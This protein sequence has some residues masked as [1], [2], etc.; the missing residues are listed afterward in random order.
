MREVQ[1]LRIVPLYFYFYFLSL[2]KMGERELGIVPLEKKKAEERVE[3]DGSGGA[4]N[5]HVR[6]QKTKNREGRNNY[7]G[8]RELRIMPLEKEKS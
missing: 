2:E 3:I 4:T 6:R 1:E 8:D 5:H 7:M